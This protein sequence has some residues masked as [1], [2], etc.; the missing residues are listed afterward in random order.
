[1]IFNFREKKSKIILSVFENVYFDIKIN[2]KIKQVKKFN[3][4]KSKYKNFT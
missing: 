4:K 2:K 3:K 1:M